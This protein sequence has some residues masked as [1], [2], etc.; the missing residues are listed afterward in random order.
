MMK[1]FRLFRNPGEPLAVSMAGIRMGDRLLLAG[2]ADPRLVAALAVKTGLTGRALAVDARPA[3]VDAAGAAAPAEGALIETAVAPWS[4]LPV[5][6][7][8]FDVAVVHDVFDGLTTGEQAS[9]AGE[10][11]RA[12]RPG[13][14]CLVI[15]TIASGGLAGLVGKSGMRSGYRSAGAARQVLEAAPFRAVRVLAAREGLEFTEAVRAN[16]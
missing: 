11:H 16:A 4:A 7:G 8:S 13:G 12:L 3:L 14:R 9:L 6:D 15:D 10:I 1:L 2:C 5:D